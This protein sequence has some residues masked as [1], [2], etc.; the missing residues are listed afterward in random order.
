[1]MKTS[2]Y[3]HK[4]LNEQHRINTKETTSLHILVKLLETKKKKE[5][6]KPT[7]IISL[8]ACSGKKKKSCVVYMGTKMRVTPDFLS[9]RQRPRMQ[10]NDLLTLLG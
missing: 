7:Q 4:K 1:M 2:N 10:W 3:R 6:K 9:G 8:K 5:K